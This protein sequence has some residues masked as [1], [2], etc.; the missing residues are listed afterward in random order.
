MA[1]HTILEKWIS[2]AGALLLLGGVTW[3]V[4]LN[5]AVL[6]LAKQA[7]V[8]QARAQELSTTIDDVVKNQTKL[9][10]I[11]ENLTDEID[12]V[13]LHSEGHTKEANGWKHRIVR[14]EERLK[15]GST[16]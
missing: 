5:V 4:Q 7:A 14:L 1:I 6:N 15:N 10:L 16:E 12:E 13:A 9:T 2:P 8:E 3:G 11:L